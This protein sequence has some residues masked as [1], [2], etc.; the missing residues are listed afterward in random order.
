MR[1]Y[2]ALFCL[3]GGAAYFWL[4]SPIFL[5]VGY[6][7]ADLTTL[8]LG[9]LTLPLRVF[10]GILK[11]IRKLMKNTF[12][13][14][15]KWY[16]IKRK[17]KAMEQAVV[18]RSARERSE[19]DH[20]LQTRQLFNQNCRAGPLIY[21]ATSLL[22]LRGANSEPPGPVGREGAAGGPTCGRKTKKKSYAIE[23]SDD[24]EVI[25]EVARRRATRIKTRCYTSTWQTEEKTRTAD[26]CAPAGEI[27]KG[28]Y[29]AQ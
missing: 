17:T 16:K 15:G 7:L 1:A 4:L 23:N 20:A 10:R 19:R 26:V 6:R 29:S 8:L 28:G 5:W 24:P 27:N 3:L 2:G 21:L 18:R 9:I 14:A 25:E 11:K 13:S 22:D 12:L